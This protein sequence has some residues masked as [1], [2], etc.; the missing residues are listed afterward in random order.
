[1]SNGVR[2]LYRGIYRSDRLLFILI[3]NITLVIPVQLSSYPLQ[4]IINTF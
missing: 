3:I 1:M 4:Y 2:I